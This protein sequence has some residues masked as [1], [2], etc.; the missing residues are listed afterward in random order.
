M[1][2]RYETVL[3]DR[4]GKEYGRNTYG[5]VAQAMDALEELESV[6]PQY[7]DAIIVEAFVRN[8]MTGKKIYR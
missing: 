6:F 2:K 5:T 4:F 8:I 7:N 3:V 1:N